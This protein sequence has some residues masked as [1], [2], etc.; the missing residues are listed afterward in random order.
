MASRSIEDKLIE[1]I[2]S[3]GPIPFSVFMEE[4]LYNEQNGFYSGGYGRAGRSGDFIT[5]P[6]V[7]PLF[8]AV[9]ARAVDKYWE[10]AGCP[11]HFVVME[12]GAGV[13]TLAISMR[14]A[15]PRS[16][17]AWV[18]VL[19]ERSPILR[20]AHHDHLEIA[21][22]VETVVSP[23]V[24]APGI[25]SVGDLTE[26]G[27]HGVILAN[28]LL[29]NVSFDLYHFGSSGWMERRVTARNGSANS[30]QLDFVDVSP[31]AVI[32]AAI[33]ELVPNPVIG[34][35]VP[36]QSRA[37]GLVERLIDLPAAGRVLIFDYG[38]ATTAELSERK[39]WGWLRLYRNQENVS[40]PLEAPGTVDVTAD[41]A[42][43]QLP[44]AEEVPMR[45]C[46]QSEFLDQHGIA[47]LVEEGRR[48]WNENA[49]SPNLAAMM[50]RSRIMEA[51][52]LQD[53]SGFGAFLVAQWEI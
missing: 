43:D 39:N 23:A 15:K 37:R 5:S 10:E 47:E 49:S 21:D 38:C 48:I 31:D 1:G 34:M 52:A 19:V 22:M 8:G 16:L 45:L 4:A 44:N 3:H 12:V 40:R 17:A 18:H 42:F 27:F 9:L 11:N 46:T 36:W 35:A 7:G 30:F 51:E 50:G 25:Y 20:E 24:L 14:A 29:D 6:E 26:G 32:T 2:R 41:V 13:G 28:E 53:P 33:S